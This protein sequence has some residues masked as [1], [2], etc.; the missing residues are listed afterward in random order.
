MGMW[1]CWQGCTDLQRLWRGHRGR[2]KVQAM[3]D[4]IARKMLEEAQ[5]GRNVAA[6]LVVV[7]IIILVEVIGYRV[8]CMC[9]SDPS[10][11]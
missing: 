11:P 7:I 2:K 10:G 1:L 6:A 3:R 5:V 8:S 4:T 9:V